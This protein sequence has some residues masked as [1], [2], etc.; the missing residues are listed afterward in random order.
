[1][2][3]KQLPRGIRNNN[4][5]NIEH[6]K[7]LWQGL[8]GTDGRFA[9]FTDVKW[10]IRAMARLL[11]NYQKKHELETIQDMIHRW[12]P[13]VENHTDSYVDVVAT[14]VGVDALEKVDA[15]RE[16]VMLPMIRAMITVENGQCP[17]S[18]DQIKEGLTL[19]GIE[20]SKS[21]KP[22]AKSRTMQ[23]VALAGVGF[24]GM[25]LEHQDML[26]T[27]AGL[28]NPGFAAALPQILVLVG[29]VR[30]AYARWDDAKK[31]VK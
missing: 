18:D 14:A 5:G 3:N 20:C 10:G 21:A 16:N 27:L 9:K 23:G 15:T 25:V 30:T 26:I 24:L 11:V 8:A 2:T 13:P 29:L 1:M 17:Y 28:V 31:G 7:D 6:G 19:A 22:L 4:P 12:A